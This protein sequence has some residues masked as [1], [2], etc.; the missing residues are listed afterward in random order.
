LGKAPATFSLSEISRDGSIALSITLLQNPDA[1]RKRKKGYAS[2][3]DRAGA[4][5]RRKI[6]VSAK[7]GASSQSAG[8]W[9]I[10]R[11]IPGRQGEENK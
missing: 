7:A 9:K 4:N 8:R 6:S 10:A 5:F 3:P 2:Q 11:V 1:L